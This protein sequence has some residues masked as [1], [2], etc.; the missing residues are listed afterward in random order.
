MLVV[1]RD[2]KV[3]GEL[4]CVCWIIGLEDVALVVDRDMLG[5]DEHPHSLEVAVEQKRVEMTCWNDRLA[6]VC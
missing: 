4:A 3:Y 5:L 2:D 1:G 6:E